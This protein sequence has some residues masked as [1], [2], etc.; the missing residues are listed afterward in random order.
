MPVYQ[1]FCLACHKKF[2]ISFPYKEYGITAVF[3]PFCN[4]NSVQRYIKN[5]QFKLAEDDSY[6][7]PDDP[8]AFAALE[9]DPQTLGKMMRKMSE[10]TGEEF[11]PEFHEVV[12][13][14][15][16]GQSFEQIEK[17][18]PDIDAPSEPPL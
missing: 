8:A 6:S 13:R 3:C 1:F 7:V 16:K 15:E 4:S 5:V 9:N 12:D 11:E 18:L 17:E 14:L 10:Q 2:E